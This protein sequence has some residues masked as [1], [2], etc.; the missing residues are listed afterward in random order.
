MSLRKD[1]KIT[2]NCFV[3]MTKKHTVDFIAEKEVKEPAIIRFDTKNG[4]VSFAGHKTVKEPV[5]VR[6]EARD[7]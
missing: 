3:F 7:N 2:I 6:F 4:P 5:E 1:T